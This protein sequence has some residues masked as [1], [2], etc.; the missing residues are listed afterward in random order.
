MVSEIVDGVVVDICTRSF[1]LIGS[2]G[3]SKTVTCDVED[4]GFEFIN[5]LAAINYSLPES[6]VVY[7]DVAIHGK[8]ND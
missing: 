5:V 4:K 2:H 7:A 1:L 8:D 6:R 3:S